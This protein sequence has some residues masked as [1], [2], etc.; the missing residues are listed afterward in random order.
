MKIDLVYYSTRRTNKT[1]KRVLIIAVILV[2]ASILSIPI[3]SAYVGW[4]LLHPKRLPVSNVPS[5]LLPNCT[6]VTFQDSNK[7]L[8]LNGWYFRTPNNAK[9]II[10]AHGYEKNRLQFGDQTFE[11]ITSLVSKGYNVLSF[12][13]RNSGLSQ[14]NVTS[15]GYY[16]KYDLLGAIQYVKSQSSDCI[17]LMGFSMGAST[18]I[19]AAAENNDVEAVIADSPFSD[20]SQYLTENLP[21][22]SGLPAQIF[23]IPI[24]YFAKRISGFD[25]VKVSPIRI[26]SKIAP[27]PILFIHSKNDKTIPIKNSEDLFK[28][29]GVNS[30]LWETNEADHVKSYTTN[31]QNYLDKVLRFLDKSHNL[32]HSIP[33]SFSN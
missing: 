19:L 32:Y 11:L 30:E 12:D 8:D 28:L 23:N 13:F 1:K 15:V 21:I 14:G 16:E 25:P 6:V 5:N 9:T 10:L 18:S 2:I 26:V 27:R 22:W 29:A 31:P 20:L 24:I 7:T 3:I 17:L 33:Q 4:D